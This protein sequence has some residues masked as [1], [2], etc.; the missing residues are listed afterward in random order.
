MKI[1]STKKILELKRLR[2][3]GY[4]INEL[5][6]KLAIPKTTV[7]HHIHA[8][9]LTKDQLLT[10]KAK[11]G[12]SHNRK[13]KSLETAKITAQ[14]LLLG[15]QRELII[16]LAMLYW[17]EGSKK[18]CEFINSDGNM[19]KLYLHV[20]RTSLKI[21][22]EKIQPTLRIFSGMDE[23]ICLDYWSTVTNMSKD[24]FRVRLND[25]S[26]SRGKTPYGM[27]RIT[28]RKGHSSLKLIHSLI[29]QFYK[30][31]NIVKLV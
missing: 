2:E 10:I 24:R 6:Q 7:W 21:P 25:G 30:E 18:V 31:I 15:P 16:A 29:E 26:T 9:P 27:C 5:V 20:L 8:I 1:H 12:G 19:I 3:Q 22:E 14:Q 4:S 28:V 13:L 11:Q 17:A 23:N